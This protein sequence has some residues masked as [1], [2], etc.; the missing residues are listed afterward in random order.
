MYK[1]TDSV[2][3]LLNRSGVGIAE[4]FSQK[5][6]EDGL[7]VPMYRVLAMLKERGESTLGELADVVSV[8]VSTLSRL[9]G[10]LSK[11]KLVSR[12]RP[13][14]NGRIV[15]VRLTQQG[16]A[17]TERLMPIAVEVENIAIAGMTDSEVDAFK[18]ALRQMRANLL[19]AGGKGKIG[20]R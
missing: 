20:N 9:I 14:D 2:P 5:I 17:L 16:E 8:E 19:S 18:N 13:E 7:T 3:Y 12:T 4:V 11:R 6:A 10:T 15:I 1:L